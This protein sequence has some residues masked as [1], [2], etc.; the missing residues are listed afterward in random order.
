[1]YLFNYELNYKQKILYC[2][3]PAGLTVQIVQ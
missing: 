2:P 1:L 3:G